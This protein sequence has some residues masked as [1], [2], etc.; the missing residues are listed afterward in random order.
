MNLESLE[1]SFQIH[2][3]LQ[4]LNSRGFTDNRYGLV[5][6]GGQASLSS[7]HIFTVGNKIFGDAPKTTTSFQKYDLDLTIDSHFK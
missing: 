5:G 1:N 3:N 4:E 7:P 2:I 6:Y